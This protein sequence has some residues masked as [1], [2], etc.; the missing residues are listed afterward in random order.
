MQTAVHYDVALMRE[1]MRDKGWFATDLAK[2]A[3]VSDMT[4]TRFLRYERQTD[5]TAVK[6]AKALGYRTAR[7]YR[8]SLRKAS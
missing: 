4:V 8:L 2:K 5:R 7:R 1:D 6:L 3:G